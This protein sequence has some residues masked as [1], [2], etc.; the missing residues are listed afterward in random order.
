MKE[1]RH[2]LAEPDVLITAVGTK[3][4]NNNGGKWTEDRGWIE[5]LD[6]GWKLDVVR[7][8]AYGALAAVGKG[9]MHF[10]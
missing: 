9:K 3:I 8:A 10:R 7:E 4:Y 5:R 6:E 2:C 1:K